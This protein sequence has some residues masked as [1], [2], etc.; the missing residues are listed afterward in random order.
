MKQDA[1]T[2]RF[3]IS[4]EDMMVSFSEDAPRND[5]VVS[6]Q[7]G[8]IRRRSIDSLDRSGTS[9]QQFRNLKASIQVQDEHYQLKAKLLSSLRELADVESLRGLA[10][11]SREDAIKATNRVIERLQKLQVEWTEFLRKLVRIDVR[12]F[13]YQD[14]GSDR[15]TELALQQ[16]WNDLYQRPELRPHG[17]SSPLEAKLICQDGVAIQQAA[18][19]HIK[20]SIEEVVERMIANLDGLVG[21]GVC[22]MITRYPEQTCEYFYAY[23]RLEVTINDPEFGPFYIDQLGKVPTRIAKNRTVSGTTKLT[24]CF[25][26]HHVIH[27]I[28]CR[29][30]DAF[31][32]VPAFHHKI[33]ESIPEWLQPHL[34]L[35]EG[36]LIS[37]QQ[38]EIEAEEREFSSTEVVPHYHNDPA[39]VLGQFVLT[40]WGPREIQEEL[41]QRESSEAERSEGDS[42]T[43]EFF[44]HLQSKVSDF[45]KS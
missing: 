10:D 6:I 12:R 37:A 31:I 41:R 28:E 7:G 35:V 38:F 8:S 19:E 16:Y 32:H 5:D 22:G 15:F 39:L 36:T 2:I 13:G 23:R 24:T 25:H 33:I 1:V 44:R 30:D 26:Q 21:L 29:P 27:A 4:E 17:V 3:P 9:D 14:D 42:P 34:A 11:P 40:G 43:G 20:E 45:F 18:L